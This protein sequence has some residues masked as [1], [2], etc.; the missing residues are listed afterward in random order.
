MPW[1]DEVPAVLVAYYPGLEGGNA[2]ASILLGE[3]NPSGKLSVTFPK[4]LEDT[5]AYINYPGT[6]EVRYGEGI[7]VGYRYYDKQGRRAALPLR[8]WPVVHHLCVQRSAGA[9]SVKPGEPVEVSLGQE[10]RRGP[11]KRSCRSTCAT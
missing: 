3:V 7:F 1:V 6:K 4:R 11:A 10:H 8:L 5:P 2:V 9:G